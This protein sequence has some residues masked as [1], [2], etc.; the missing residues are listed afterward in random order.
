LLV[1]MEK[2]NTK[3]KGKMRSLG[4][5]TETLNQSN[6]SIIRNNTKFYATNK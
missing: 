5:S 6:E 2:E 4:Q 3:L 1:R